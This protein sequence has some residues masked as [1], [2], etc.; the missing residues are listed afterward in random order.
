M[1]KII[2]TNLAPIDETLPIEQ[3]VAELTRRVNLDTEFEDNAWDVY[4]AGNYQGRPIFKIKDG[5]TDST[6]DYVFADQTSVPL[7]GEM[8]LKELYE[9]TQAA[10]AKSIRTNPAN[11]LTHEDVT[12]SLVSL[13]VMPVHEARATFHETSV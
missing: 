10:I 4:P 11:K 2:A 1:N 12:K 7:E 3:I 13:L 5:W 9:D 6:Y 8:N